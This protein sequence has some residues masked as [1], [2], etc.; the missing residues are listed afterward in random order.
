MDIGLRRVLNIH[1]DVTLSFR[2][3]ATDPPLMTWTCQSISNNAGVTPILVINPQPHSEQVK[4]LRRTKED[5]KID[6][7]VSMRIYDA[8]FLIQGPSN[9]AMMA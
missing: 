4:G 2:L 9:H 6:F 3:I 1:R 5:K 7:E 8:A